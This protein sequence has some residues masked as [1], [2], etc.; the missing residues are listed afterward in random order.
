MIAAGLMAQQVQYTLSKVNTGVGGTNWGA[1]VSQSGEMIFCGSNFDVGRKTRHTKLYSLRPG[2]K[3]QA[4][5]EEESRELRHMGA[6]YITPDGKE[7]YFAVSGKI[8]ATRKVGK[9]IEEYFP[10][11]IARSQRNA[12]GTWG[13]IVMFRYNLDNYSSGD[14]WMSNDGEYLYFSSDRP[15]GAGGE[16]IWRSRKD[17]SGNWI[18][19]ENVQELNTAADER[20]P[21]FDPDGNFYFSTQNESYGGLDIFSCG[22][23]SNGHFTT[24]V[25][26]AMPLNSTDDDFAITFID[27]NKGYM[28]SNRSKED[29]IYKF[30][31][32]NMELT[33]TVT[34]V[35]IYNDPIPDAQ[36]YFMSKEASDFKLLTTNTN[37][38]VTTKLVQDAR[39]SLLA[40][41][42]EYIPVEYKDELAKN[43]TSRTVTLEGV[44]TCVSPDETG[45]TVFI[46]PAPIPKATSVMILANVNFDLDKWNIRPDAARQLDELAQYLLENWSIQLEISAYTDCRASAAY[47]VMLSQKRANSVKRYLESKGI[48][49]RR[50]T[51][52]GYGKTKP[53]NLCDCQRNIFCTDAEYEVNRRAEFTFIRE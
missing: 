31:R 6:P 4:L 40:Y 16:D 48:E 47:N 28:S 11:Q 52:V 36:V 51:A 19:P 38:Q 2:S 25:R 3:A 23:L 29:A 33:A 35:D 27:E 50:M 5:F 14:P 10:L 12:D 49:A 17:A 13:P 15:G 24:P 22:L 41:K 18:A 21:R 1:V 42:Q 34:V 45:T 7:L 8:K 43:Y 32:I 30:E 9:I 39:Y 20:S 53:L 37:G 44:P 26:M 46:E